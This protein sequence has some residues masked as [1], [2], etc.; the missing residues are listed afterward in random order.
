MVL[1]IN[2]STNDLKYYSDIIDCLAHNASNPKINKIVLFCGTPCDLWENGI[3][4]KVS[5]IKTNSG[6]KEAMNYVKRISKKY[7]I[8]STPFVKFTLDIDRLFSVVNEKVSIKD[9]N[10]YYVFHKSKVLVNS[11]TIDGMLG[12]VE[13]G[14]SFPKFGYFIKDRSN[15][16]KIGWRFNK[17]NKIEEDLKSDKKKFIVSKFKKEESIKRKIDVVI[18]SVNYNDYLEITLPLNLKIFN[19]I[20]IVTTKEDKNCIE[21]CEKYNVNI[22]LTERLYENGAEFNK[23]KAINDGIES[24]EDP[25]FI[26]LLDSDIIVTEPIDIDSLQ[27][28]VLYYCDR[29][30]LEKYEDYESFLSGNT[31][32]NLE[33]SGPIG[34]FQLFD[35]KK[36]LKVGKYPIGSSDASWSDVKFSR[37]ITKQSKLIH[38]VLHLGQTGINWKGRVSSNFSPKNFISSYFDNIYCINLDRR[39]DRWDRVKKEFDRFDLNVERFSAIDGGSFDSVNISKSNLGKIEN[40]AALSCLLSH[41]YVIKDAKLKGYSR[42]LIFEDDVFLSH[43]FEENIKNISNID[44][45]MMYLGASQFDWNEIEVLDGFYKC[46]NTLGTFAYCLDSSLYDKVLAEFE[47]KSKSVDNIFSHI[48]SKYSD[49]CYTIYPNIVISDVSES[50]IRGGKEMVEYSNS[51]RWDLNKFK[52]NNKLNILLVPDVIGWAFDNIANSICKYNPYPDKISYD[53]EYIVDIRNG[54]KINYKKYDYIYVFFE[55]EMSIPIA[56]NVIRGCYSAFWL[57]N[58]NFSQKKIGNIFSKCGGAIFVNETL[59]DSISP[60][61]PDEFPIEV[62]HDSADENIFYPIDDIKSDNFTVIF[63]G[64]ISRPV[65]RFKEIEEICKQ[66]NVELL[67]CSNIKN[68]E[69]VYYYNKADIC[70]NFSDSEGGPQTFLESSLCGVPMLIRSNNDLSKKIP[71]FVGE[72]KE[73]FI[74]I[75]KDLKLEGG[76][77]KCISVGKEARKVVLNQFIYSKTAVK[78]ADFF[79]RLQNPLECEKIISKKDLSDVLTIFVIRCGY[80]PNYDDC[81]SALMS[82][83][84][85]FELIEIKDKTPMSKAFQTMI[86]KCQ[87][88][89]YIQVD[90]D[91]ILNEDAI[92]KIY[93]SL[94]K[95][96]TNIS[97][98]AHMLRDVHLDFD[99]FGVKGYKHS[100]L[101]KYPYNLNII[102]CEMDQITRMQNDGYE[103]LMVNE[104]FGQHSPKWT[105]NL[106][107]ERY[108]DLMEKYKVFGYHWMGELPAKL[109]QILKNNPSNENIYAMMGAMVS[110]ATEDKL[111]SREKNFNIEDKNFKRIDSLLS[112]KDFVHIINRN[113]ILKR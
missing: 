35:Y 89:Y 48:Q 76:K 50:D 37:Y 102:S 28:N 46:K 97:I 107:F 44:W 94:D 108:F 99:I 2:I 111:R 5:I 14:P 24:L 34:Y 41:Y 40:N 67:V 110:M 87:T 9:D 54:K 53:I 57:E 39:K 98:V 22:V 68:D 91:M 36:Y 11:S 79:L 4:K 95:S 90:E 92:E 38:P 62:I 96:D 10:V 59:K 70:I 78:F 61:L 112:K 21:I 45:M 55:A 42:I 103:I 81:I 52:W 17:E 30:N 74:K 19:N 85:N 88:K 47:K 101:K 12:L 33:S 3:S 23:G 66:A 25:D 7:I 18:V 106:I 51:M 100:V 104:V 113:Y 73:D 15:I 77:D 32:Y 64:N 56:D 80:N 86:D 65:K 75:I 29:I 63:V 27:N 16:E 93:E 1:V 72:T 6:H 49:Y 43:D 71:C 13:K 58:S 69:L 83:T 26:L 84:V 20:T 82:Q 8:Y 60:Y 105:N 109:L 31:K